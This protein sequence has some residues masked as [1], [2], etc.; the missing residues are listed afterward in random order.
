V[1]KISVILGG[2]MNETW[3]EIKLI[4]GTQ[5]DIKTKFEIKYMDGIVKI[6]DY[7]FPIRSILYIKEI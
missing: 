6:G 3:Y 7:I 1:I 4:D 5:V 2:S